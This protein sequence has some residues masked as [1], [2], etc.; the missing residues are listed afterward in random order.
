MISP[1]TGV[2]MEWPNVTVTKVEANDITGDCI[3]HGVSMP[4]VESNSLQ[5]FS[6]G[7]RDNSE[8]LLETSP[9]IEG[10]VSD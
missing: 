4:G 5:T 7:E 2:M 10:R 3:E 8:E 6:P 9:V 1:T